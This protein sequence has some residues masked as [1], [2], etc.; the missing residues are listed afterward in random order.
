MILSECL[1]NIIK[2]CFSRQFYDIFEISQKKSSCEI[3][4]FFRKNFDNI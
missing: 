3:W 4:M 2:K 1:K